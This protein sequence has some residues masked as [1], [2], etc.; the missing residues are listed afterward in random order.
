MAQLKILPGAD[1]N[2]QRG[3]NFASPTAPTDATNKAYVDNLIAGLTWKDEVRA[4]TTGNGTLATAY[5]ATQ[6]LDGIVLATNDRILIKDQTSQIEN[7][8]YIVSATGAPTRS[9]DADSPT[10][11]NNA[12]VLVTDGTVNTGR[13][14]T[15][16]TKNPIVG[17][18]NITWSQ[19]STGITYTA[20]GNGITLTGTQFSLA[21]DG[22]SLSKSG[23]GLRIGSAAAGAGLIE[24][25]GIL[26][27]GSGAGISVAADSVAIDTSVVVRKFSQDIGNGSLSSIPVTHALGTKDV[28]VTI[29]ENS[30][31]TVVLTEWAATS[32]SVV[33]VS[34]PTAPTSAQ[35][36]ATI[37]A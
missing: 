16:T 30:T 21:L 12:T 4:A 29:R 36:R 1:L 19:G 32:T 37:Q 14:Y 31:D 34:F 24:S 25:A 3:I 10:D 23:S 5:A 13:S 9:T 7:G 15:Q 6:T 8:I 22:T 17:T 27:V 28:Q 11:L 26:A 2:N 35:Y 33:T 18:S 20:D